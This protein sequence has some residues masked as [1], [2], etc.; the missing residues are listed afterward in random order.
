MH[1]VVFLQG[2]EQNDNW[3][4]QIQPSQFLQELLFVR[5]RDEGIGVFLKQQIY[6]DKGLLRYNI[7]E[8]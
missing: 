8:E 3:P 1:P 5:K 6:L 2:K 7:H 4:S